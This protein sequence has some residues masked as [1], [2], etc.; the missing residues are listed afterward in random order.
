MLAL[1][2][3]VGVTLRDLARGRRPLRWLYSERMRRA[4]SPRRHHWLDALQRVEAHVERML[5]SHPRRLVVG[6]LMTLLIESLIVLQYHALLDAF[7]VQLDLPS[8]LLV[9]LGGGLASALPTPAG[10]GALEATQVLLVGASTGRPQLGF[11]VGL[12]VRLHQTVLLVAG[13]AALAWLG[14]SLR[15]ARKANAP[16]I[17]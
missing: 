3:V 12:L 10:L 11:I 14:G 17:D 16:A 5:Q 13:L 9:L 7:G 8:L 6:L 4:V 1:L 15:A 2:G